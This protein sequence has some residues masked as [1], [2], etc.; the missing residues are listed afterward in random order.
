[1]ARNVHAR[2]KFEHS[3]HHIERSTH[4]IKPGAFIRSAYMEDAMRL[5]EW[6]DH[7]ETV[8]GATTAGGVPNSTLVMTRL[9]D[10]Y[11]AACVTIHTNSPCAPRAPRAALQSAP[12]ILVQ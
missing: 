11:P 9:H 1:V 5:A 6:L 7:V 8:L 12:V 3:P 4:L 2:H 10:V